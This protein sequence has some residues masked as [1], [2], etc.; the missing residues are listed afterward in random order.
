MSI[1]DQLQRGGSKGESPAS[2][3]ATFTIQFGTESVNV[4]VEPGQTLKQAMDRHMQFLGYDGSR[5]VTWREGNQVIS[6]SAQPRAGALYMA[7]V[8]LETKGR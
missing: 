3:G 5:A 4:P 6:E 8:S 7:S 1:W 2:S